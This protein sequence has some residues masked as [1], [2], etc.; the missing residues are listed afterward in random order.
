M[1][2]IPISTTDVSGTSNAGEP[3]QKYGVIVV[4]AGFSGIA[5]LHRLRKD[6]LKVHVFESGTHVFHFMD[7]TIFTFYSNALHYTHAFTMILD[8]K[9]ISAHS[10]LSIPKVLYCLLS[11]APALA[12]HNQLYL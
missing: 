11:L 12:F 2:A 9:L 7:G 5:N 8:I 6:G 10:I 1:A 4:G 3:V